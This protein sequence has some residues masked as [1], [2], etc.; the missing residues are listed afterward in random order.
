V[1]GAEIPC[2]YIIAEYVNGEDQ[3]PRLRPAIDAVQATVIAS[4]L[5]CEA[6]RPLVK[7]FVFTEQ[8]RSRL[9]LT[10]RL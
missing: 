9:V 7:V 5:A 3:P 10:L 6:H 4:Q 1:S 2:R 8:G